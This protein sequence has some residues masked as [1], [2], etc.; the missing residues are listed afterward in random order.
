MSATVRARI[1]YP[2]RHNSSP[3]S[4]CFWATSVTATSDLPASPD[5]Q[6]VP[7]AVAA[8]VAETDL[9]PLNGGAQGPFRYIVGR[10]DSLVF[11][12]REQP[13]EVNE[14]RC[15][16]VAHLAVLIVQVGLRQGEQ[17]LLQRDRLFQQLPPVKGPRIPAPVPQLSAKPVPKPEQ[18]GHH[19]QCV[20]A[21]LPC[22]GAARTIG[23]PQDVPLQMSPA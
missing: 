2:W 14:Q 23:N 12:K 7:I 16:Q 15:R 4:P 19:G 6:A 10:L 18:P 21:K 1:G 22:R 11:Q 17:H 20:P 5:R 13:F 8:A 9:A 3:A